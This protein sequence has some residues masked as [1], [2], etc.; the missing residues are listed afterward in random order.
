[1][2]NSYLEWLQHPDWRVAAY[3]SAM[4]MWWI[5]RVLLFPMLLSG[6]LVRATIVFA[7]RYDVLARP[8]ERGSHTIPTPRLGG[9][10]S[11]AAFYITFFLVSMWA[12]HYSM[13]PWRM[14]ILLG[15]TWALLGG[16]LDD[17]QELPPRWKLLLQI[18]ACGAVPMLGFAPDVLSLPLAGD[19]VLSPTAATIVAVLTTLFLM[20]IFNFMDGMDGLAATFGIVTAGTLGLYIIVQVIQMRLGATSVLPAIFAGHSAIVVGSLIG[21][22]SCNYPGRNLNKKTFMGDCGSQFY[23]FVIAVLALQAGSSDLPKEVRFPWIASLILFSPFVYD[24][25]FTLIRRI[26]RG[27]NLTQAHRTHLYQ[28]LMVAG[29][30]HGRALVFNLGLY[31][32]VAGLAWAYAW[33][34]TKGYAFSRLLIVLLTGGLL[35]AYTFAVMAVENQAQQAARRD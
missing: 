19:V 13:E 7:R 17:F 25:V 14:V 20:N 28:R 18:A 3:A 34:E 15:G 6:L 26:R 35:A 33:C 4:G 11:A 32:V 30:S 5:S 1:M 16:A 27:E 24:V 12:G 10:G 23:G 22:L 21:L 29:W 9:L 2:G 31:V 8:S